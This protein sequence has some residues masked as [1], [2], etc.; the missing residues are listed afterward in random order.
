MV[1]FFMR[2]SQVRSNVIAPAWHLGRNDT[3][4]TIVVGAESGTFSSRFVARA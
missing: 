2:K 4:E 3:I 1:S